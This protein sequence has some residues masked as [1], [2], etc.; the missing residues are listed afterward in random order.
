MFGEHHSLLNDFPE[1][2]DKIHELKAANPDFASM[3][4]EYDRV[5]KEVYKIEEQIETRS[6]AYTE[7]LKK[8]RVML[9]DK[10][11]ALLTAP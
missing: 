7:D 3:Y 11:Y 2:R 10:L 9:K 5:D 4:E 6:D 1:L 8:R